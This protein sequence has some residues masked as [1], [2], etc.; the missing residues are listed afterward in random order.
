MKVNRRLASLAVSLALAGTISACG[1]GGGPYVPVTRDPVKTPYQHS[2]R[3]LTLDKNVRDIL[4]YVDSV[5]ERLPGGQI[6]IRASFQNRLEQDVWA[7]VKTEFLGADNMVVDETEWVET[8]FPAWEV[9]AV[10]A[11]SITAGAVKHTLLLRNIRNRTGV[12]PKAKRG[13]FAVPGSGY[14]IPN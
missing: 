14:P 4:L 5:Q 1:G 2:Q 9:T 11:N 8:H 7:E 6:S 10:K 13:I 3:I 12:L